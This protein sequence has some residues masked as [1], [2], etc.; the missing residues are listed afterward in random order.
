MSSPAMAIRTTPCTPISAKRVASLRH[1]SSGATAS[2]F[3]A[4]STCFA[5]A[6]KLAREFKALETEAEAAEA[7]A[8]TARLALTERLK[9]EGVNSIKTDGLSVTWS[10][11]RGREVCDVKALRAAAAQAEIDISQ[12]ISTSGRS[13]RLLVRLEENPNSGIKNRNKPRVDDSD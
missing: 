13:D 4:L 11:V 10:Q 7:K 2:P 12:F 3:T 6:M 9:A 1:R 8:K 5:E